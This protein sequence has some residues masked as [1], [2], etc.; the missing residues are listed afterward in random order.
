[1]YSLAELAVGL[2]HLVYRSVAVLADRVAAAR[3]YTRIAVPF[4][5]VAS[6]PT[7]TLLT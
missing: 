4:Y 1:M 2:L 3:N 5:P 6:R 7:S